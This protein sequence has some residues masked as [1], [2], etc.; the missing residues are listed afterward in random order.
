MEADA[1]DPAP[2]A[3]GTN[4]PAVSTPQITLTPRKESRRPN[5]VAVVNTGDL[6]AAMIWEHNAGTWDFWFC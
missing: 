4:S 5:V 2:A 3:M 1:A 6:R